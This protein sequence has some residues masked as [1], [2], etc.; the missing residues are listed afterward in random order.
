MTS[1]SVLIVL[2]FW[3][4]FRPQRSLAREGCTRYLPLFLHSYLARVQVRTS[5]PPDL[6]C[7]KSIMLVYSSLL[8][9]LSNQPSICQEAI[10][11]KMSISLP[12]SSIAFPINFLTAINSYQ[13]FEIIGKRSESGVGERGGTVVWID[14]LDGFPGI[15]RTR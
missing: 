2:C 3:M 5:A 14:N 8:A 15:A 6:Q 12:L 1:G 4:Y 10:K 7:V 9:S 11:Q 13:R